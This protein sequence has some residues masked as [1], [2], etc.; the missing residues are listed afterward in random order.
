[1][2]WLMWWIVVMYSYIEMAG[3]NHP[4]EGYSYAFSSDLVE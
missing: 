1:M 4:H 3:D 2:W